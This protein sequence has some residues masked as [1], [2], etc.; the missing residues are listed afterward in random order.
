MYTLHKPDSRPCYNLNAQAVDLQTL[1]G[2]QGRIY[3]PGRPEGA[4][5][6][7]PRPR[8]AHRRPG[9]AGAEGRGPEVPPLREALR[10]ETGPGVDAWPNQ[11][12]TS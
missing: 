10:A 5:A 8:E 6:R 1:M 7:H 11:G 2:G 9:G 3:Q 12:Q 4:G